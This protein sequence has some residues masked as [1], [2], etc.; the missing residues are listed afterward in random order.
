[1]F[2]CPWPFRSQRQQ[3]ERWP[4][5]L[6]ACVVNGTASTGD[7]L[8]ISYSRRGWVGR[9]IMGYARWERLLR[10]EECCHRGIRRTLAWLL[11]VLTQSDSRIIGDWAVIPVRGVD[12]HPVW[13]DCINPYLLVTKK[14]TED[15]WLHHGFTSMRQHTIYFYG[16]IQSIPW[17]VNVLLSAT[18][19]CEDEY[20]SRSKLTALQGVSYNIADW[21]STNVRRN[22][23]RGLACHVDHINGSS[24]WI[25]AIWDG[26]AS[27]FMMSVLSANQYKGDVTRLQAFNASSGTISKL[28]MAIPPLVE[29]HRCFNWKSLWEKASGLSF[30]PAQSC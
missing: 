22:D 13:E 8:S 25:R 10:A 14:W 19:D 17:V 15:D 1:M 7:E 6:F 4:S 9:D 3:I 11:S 20:A 27:W 16:S 18:E 26:Y 21:I 12:G 23:C 5:W 30:S 28:F 29:W 24:I 2:S